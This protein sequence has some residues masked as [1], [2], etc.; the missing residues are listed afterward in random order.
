MTAISDFEHVYIASKLCKK[1]NETTDNQSSKRN[2]ILKKLLKSVGENSFMRTPINFDIGQNTTIGDNF[3]SNHNLTVMDCGEVVIGDNVRIGPN[4]VLAVAEHPKDK[5]LR[6][7]EFEHA[8]PIVIKDD[9]WIGAN[10]TVLCGVTIGE[11][12]IIGA[13]SVVT[14]DIPDNCIA[15]GVPCK[16]TKKIDVSEKK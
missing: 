6:R 15:C 7:T 9:V 2:K 4:C 8:E 14:K 13:G 11:G 5:I 12:S 1:Y 3:F 16:V 10:V